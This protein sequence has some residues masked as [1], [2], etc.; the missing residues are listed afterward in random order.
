MKIKINKDKIFLIIVIS[1]ILTS[2]L[3]YVFNSNYGIGISNI[4]WTFIIA[5]L[6]LI[7]I[8][9]QKFSKWLEKPIKS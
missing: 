6:T 2:I 3:L 5:I 7:Q 9:N 8:F 4:I 1:W